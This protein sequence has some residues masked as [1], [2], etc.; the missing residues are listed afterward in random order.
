MQYSHTVILCS[1]NIVSL[2]GFKTNFNQLITTFVLLTG[3]HYNL[4]NIYEGFIGAKSK[5]D[6]LKKLFPYIQIYALTILSTYSQ[7]FHQYVVLFL[8]GLGL[9]QTYIAGLLNIASTASIDF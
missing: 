3:I 6:A 1:N 2:F 9:F 8:V 7:F 5:S 4:T